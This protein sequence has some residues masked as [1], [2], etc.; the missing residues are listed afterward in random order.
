MELGE[1]AQ[2]R[3]ADTHLGCFDYRVVMD[4]L[5]SVLGMLGVQRHEQSP[6]HWVIEQT[7]MTALMTDADVQVLSGICPPREYHRGDRLYRSGDA[8]HSLFVLLDGHVKISTPAR[9]GGERIVTVCGPDDFFGESFLTGARERVSD[10]VCLSDTAIACA[11]SRDQFLEIA[12]KAPTVALA[13]AVVLAEHAQ[14]LQAQLDHLTRPA[15]VRLARTLISLAE[16]FGREEKPGWME[17]EVDL[18]HEDL[19]GLAHLS[20][21]T[22]TEY[23]SAWR[24]QELVL[25]T[26]GRYVINRE[27]LLTLCEQLEAEQ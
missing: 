25:G 20:R 8:A 13:F 10:A 5:N 4:S 16:R 21:V 24:T 27:G 6:G 17:L 26:R 22:V 11:I 15:P 19:A 14:R 3:R 9:L 18:K 2:C 1:N 23:L 7:G 12:R